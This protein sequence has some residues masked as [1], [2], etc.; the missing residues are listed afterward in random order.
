MKKAVTFLFLSIIACILYPS[1]TQVWINEIHYDNESTDTGEAIELCAPAGHSTNQWKI[2][3]YNGYNGKPYEVIDIDSLS[4]TNEQNGYGVDV[5]YFASNGIQNGSPDGIAIINDSNQVV[6]FVSY[7]GS[8][9][10]TEGP[11]A[12]ITSTIIPVQESNSTPLGYSIQLKG[13]G[14]AYE[15]FYWDEP[16]ANSFGNINDGQSIG[17]NK[18]EINLQINE[19]RVDQTGADKDEYFELKGTPG[20][21]LGYFTYIVLGDKSESN[22]IIEEAITLNGLQINADSLCLVHEES[23]SLANKANIED[24]NFEN[25]DNVTH[26]LVKNFTGS[27]GDDLDT[28][29]DGTLDIIPWDTIVDALA[30]INNQPLSGDKIYSE[31]VI[32]SNESSHPFHVFRDINNI[33]RLGKKDIADGNDTPGKRNYIIFSIPDQ[34]TF[35]HEIQ[36]T[37]QETQLPK[38]SVLLIEGIVT[39]DYQDQDKLKGFFIQEE[40]TDYDNDSLTSEGIFVFAA[41][42]SFDVNIGDKIKVVGIA[43]EYYGLTELTNIY[44]IERIDSAW[45]LPSPKKINLPLSELNELERHEGMLVRFDQELT[46]TGTHNLHKYGE[47]MFSSNGRLYNPTQIV[48]PGNEALMLKKENELNRIILNDMSSL[49]YP[50][51][52]IYPNTELTSD[53]TL[54]VGHTIN[55]LS[56][57]LNYSFGN[58]KVEP[59]STPLFSSGANPRPEDPEASDFNLKISSF[60]VL[61]YFNGE[62]TD[63]LFPT[64]RG[65]DNKLEFSRQSEKIITA[66]KKINAD[67]F[68]L[69]ELENDGFSDHSAIHDLV[70]TLNERIGSEKY[71]YIKPK[72]KFI[73]DD[74]ITV[75]IIYKNSN[76]TPYK[77]AKILD[78]TVDTLFNDD[79]NRPS[80]AQSFIDNN[81]GKIFTVVVN[82]FKSKGSPCNDVNDPDLMDGQG[83]CNL[84]RTKAAQALVNWIDTDPT[85]SK[86][87]N[88]IL[89]GDFNA[90]AKED[91][92]TLIKNSGYINL[93]EKSDSLAYSYIYKGESGTLDHMF[94][95]ENMLINVLGIKEWH[96]NADEPNALNYNLENKTPRQESILYAIDPYRSSD[97]DPI[98]LA[99]DL[100]KK[101]P[102]EVIGFTLFDS[103]TGDNI[104]NIDN[105]DTIDYDAIKWKK[106]NIRVNTINAP[107][108]VFVMLSGRQWYWRLDDS[109]P[110][111]LFWNKRG[112]KSEYFGIPLTK[113]EHYITSF[114]FDSKHGWDKMG[115]PKC[116]KFYI[117]D[118]DNSDA[119]SDGFKT[120][121]PIS[122]QNEG[123]DHMNIF[124]NPFDDQVSI[125]IFTKEEI[126][127]DLDIYDN[128]GKKVFSKSI[129][130][131]KGKN[132]YHEYLSHLPSGIYHVTINKLNLNKTITKY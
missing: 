44:S 19:L 30:L 47:V 46:V 119:P 26:L 123:I 60:N 29:N 102:S 121:G 33:W 126:N 104:A 85:G 25:N 110:F 57:V 51:T 127:V 50:D 16:S 118:I 63:K 55:N 27:S 7:E 34:I 81:T 59:T 32:S 28:N 21:D 20:F 109:K 64:A 72:E 70:K 88:F 84:T 37:G 86:S 39:A 43:K 83:N 61:N 116:V 67:I 62:G 66:L 49:S 42:E 120:T 79:K 41:S 75:G 1:F 35:I 56:G 17:F 40:E 65:A 91:P 82:H 97:H 105:N 58:Y 117:D 10:A 107:E 23:F 113:G 77:E 73:G 2:V 14:T 71:R 76:V 38:D 69:M 111:T 13:I 45:P 92:I 4:F 122:A 90:Y 114:P 96:I 112:N 3:L 78:S 24:L 124:P 48:K 131:T 53:N 101:M 125:D 99:L 87:N 80:L 108:K 22:G 93:Q 103:K 106:L 128:Y 54:R 94:V 132:S 11:A 6:Q 9:T 74:E 12:N 68:G 100:S 36:G 18:G 95:S 8:I 52:I 15:D 89:L 98:I 129:S 115:K 31:Q 5:I 130:L